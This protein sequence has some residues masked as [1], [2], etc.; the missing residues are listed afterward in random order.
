MRVV[1]INIFSV[2]LNP[3]ITFGGLSREREGERAM[4]KRN[5]KRINT[6]STTE[7]LQML[8]DKLQHEVN[9]LQAKNVKNQQRK[10]KMNTSLN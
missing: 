4:E 8:V 9:E 2:Q 5:I 1:A 7:A 3:A 6:I 10:T